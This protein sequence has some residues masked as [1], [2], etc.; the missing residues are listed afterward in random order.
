MNDST[1]ERFSTV[2]S[3]SYIQ[4]TIPYQNPRQREIWEMQLNHQ[5]RLNYLH[6]K[7]RLEGRDSYGN[8]IDD[9]QQ[10]ALSMQNE[11]YDRL[12]LELRQLEAALEQ[13]QKLLNEAKINT[14]QEIDK[15]K[16]MLESFR[17]ERKNKLEAKQ[18]ENAERKRKYQED[19]SELKQQIANGKSDIRISIRQV[20]HSNSG[21]LL[22]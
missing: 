9:A 17:I 2:R 22:D 13:E 11:E 8:P 21:S 10:I 15:C 1:N 3:R 5:Q 19:I 18:K 14:N 20:N 6:F 7:A 4:P 16:K 12:E